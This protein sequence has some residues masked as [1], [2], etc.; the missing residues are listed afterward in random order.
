MLFR[1]ISVVFG[2][3]LINGTSIVWAAN[4]IC[5]LD[6]LFRQKIQGPATATATATATQTQNISSCGITFVPASNEMYTDRHKL[7]TVQ[8]TKSQLERRQIYFQTFPKGGD[9]HIHLAGAI[10]PE[11]LIAIGKKYGD[12]IEPNT[13][14]AY[15]KKDCKHFMPFKSLSPQ[16]YQKTLDAWSL[17]NLPHNN[18]S[19]T[20]ASYKGHDHFFNAFEK[21]IH[22]TDAHRTD[23]MATTLRHAAAHHIF[24][25]ELMN[26]LDSNAVTGLTQQ[27]PTTLKIDKTHFSDLRK[28]LQKKPFFDL[29]KKTQAKL[30]T[31][32][33]DLRILLNCQKPSHS[34][35]CEIKYKFLYEVLREQ[36]PEKIFASLLFGFELA[37]KDPNVVGI[38][39]SQPED[40]TLAV[41]D[42]RL[43]MSMIEFLKT[44]YPKVNIS[45]HA[46][47]L[48]PDLVQA[49]DL[50][51]HIQTAI[52]TGKAQRIGHGTSIFYESNL[53]PLLKIMRDQKIA[54]EINLSSNKKIL[55]ISGTQHPFS[56]YLKHQ[57]PV[58]LSTDDEGLL[59]SSLSGEYQKAYEQHHLNYCELKQLSR[60]SLTYSFLPGEN[61]WHYLPKSC[62]SKKQLANKY[63]L[64]LKRSP[65]AALQW[66]LE[67]AF[68][69]YENKLR[70]ANH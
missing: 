52:H 47:E 54:I 11:E 32:A 14:K 34:A 50:N 17:K 45:L 30:K 36:S 21:F 53:D 16:L 12:C 28:Q 40:G 58:V 38:N 31:R 46:G 70:K 42:Y 4:N 55:G 67:E 66:Q 6:D 62:H 69:A 56:F 29:I 19:E 3:V 20:T 49:K 7:R 25:L 59:R 60:D 37:T 65:K 2:C 18:I 63:K 24:Y 51:F 27:L 64:L 1:A 68:V 41:R 61:L 48:T 26:T 9:L 22:L 35:A 13:L 33:Q 39:L 23:L 43:H 57:I 5:S 15:L 10:Y 8:A 44:Y